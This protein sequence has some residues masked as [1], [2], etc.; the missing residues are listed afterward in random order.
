MK[1]FTKFE[2]AIIIDSLNFARSNDL[3]KH[4]EVV[5]AGKNP[6]MTADYIEQTYND[7]IEKVREKTKK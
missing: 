3:A 4:Q 5:Q 7:L 1:K 2:S 6:I